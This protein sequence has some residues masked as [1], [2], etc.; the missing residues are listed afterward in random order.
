[1][2]THTCMLHV[3]VKMSLSP[4][5]FLSLSFSLSFLPL[6][7]PISLSP[8]LS[9]S[10]PLSLP[11]ALTLSFS[12]FLPFPLPPSTVQS[13]SPAL[14]LTGYCKLARPTRLTFRTPKRH[15]LLLKGTMLS[16]FKDEDD[17]SGGRAPIQ[18]LNLT[19]IPLLVR[20]Y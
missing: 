9:P 17:F 20:A 12:P 5:L 7:L 3:C 13:E 8:P 14:Q 10:L 19:G 1:M 6:S 2:Y 18:K 16:Y 4:F 15:F 11:L